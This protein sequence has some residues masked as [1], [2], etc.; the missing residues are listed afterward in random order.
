M[1][2]AQWLVLSVEVTGMLAYVAYAV[3]KR[4]QK[5]TLLSRRYILKSCHLGIRRQILL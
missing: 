2:S 1:K 3:V 4:V 5:S